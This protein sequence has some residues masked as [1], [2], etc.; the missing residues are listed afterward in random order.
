MVDS[1]KCFHGKVPVDMANAKNTSISP[2]PGYNPSV[3]AVKPDSKH[4]VFGTAKRVTRGL[5]MFKD[6]Q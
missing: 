2:G 1:S 5:G 4:P 6:T 3:D